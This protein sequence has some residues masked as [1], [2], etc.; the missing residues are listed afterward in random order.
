MDTVFF[1]E[2]INGIISQALRSNNDAKIIANVYEENLK[3]D[4]IKDRLKNRLNINDGQLVIKNM[5]ASEFLGQELNQ[6]KL[7]EYVSTKTVFDNYN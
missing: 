6:D 1:D 2:H 5:K 4:M 7:K 3:D